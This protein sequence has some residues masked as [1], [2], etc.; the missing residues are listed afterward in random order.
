MEQQRRPG[1]MCPF[2]DM[3]GWHCT[4]YD[5]RPIL[6]RLYGR[7]PGLAC[8]LAPEEAE[9]VTHAAAMAQ[10]MAEWKH[11]RMAGVL[12]ASLRWRE[13]RSALRERAKTV[14]ARGA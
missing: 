1:N 6:C 11:A 4:V 5:S 13:I 9:A 12:G 3:Q 10:L 14:M 2:V 7:T 8:P